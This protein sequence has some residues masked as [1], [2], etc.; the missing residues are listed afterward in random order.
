[1]IVVQSCV[2]LILHVCDS[3][4]NFYSTQLD[5]MSCNWLKLIYEIQLEAQFLHIPYGWHTI[6]DK[7]T[8]IKE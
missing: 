4:V 2:S 3:M 1:M 5:Y 8:E 7:S 6:R